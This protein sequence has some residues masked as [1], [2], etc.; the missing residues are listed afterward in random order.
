MVMKALLLDSGYFP[1]QMLDWK[2]AM[3]L[4]FTGR[5]EVVEHHDD[6]K[7]RSTH[8]S[9]KLPKV[10]RLFQKFNSFTQI[11]FNRHNIFYRDKYLCQYCGLKFNANDLTLDHILPKSRGGGTHWL[12]IV[13]SCHSC[14]NRKK[15]NTPEECDMP[16]LHKPRVPRWNPIFVFKLSKSEIQIFQHWLGHG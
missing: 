2:S 14:N 5:A 3:L 10:M 7:I 12:N 6:I 1:V 11:K 4:C 15:N 9:F 8:S 13:S 16:L